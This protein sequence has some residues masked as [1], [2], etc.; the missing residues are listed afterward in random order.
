MSSDV[1]RSGFSKVLLKWWR[2]N[3][4]EFPWRSTKNPYRILMAEVLLHRTR[5]EQVVP[6]YM[7]FI[8]RFPTIDSLNDARLEDIQDVVRRLGLHWRTELLV[9]MAREVTENY[10]GRVPRSRDDL[11]S[12]SGISDYIASAIR[13]FAFDY[14]DPLLDT[15]TTRILGRV[16]NVIV[17]DSA[18]RSQHFYRLYEKVGTSKNPREFAFAMIDLGALVCL[19][20]KPLCKVC[21]VRG[22]C[23]Y[24][25]SGKR[26]Y[27]QT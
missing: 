19:P 20:K 4:R 11:K 10:K 16:F 1:D 6:V 23:I 27:N 21:P 14:C 26:S 13:C 15:N 24:F 7:R 12:L 18:R 22:M 5:A 17:T 2:C 8:N 25:L 3:K 9:R